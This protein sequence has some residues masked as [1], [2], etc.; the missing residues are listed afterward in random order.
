MPKR[1]AL[2]LLLTISTGCIY[3]QTLPVGS[4]VIEDA[5]RRL[6]ISGTLPSDI[7]YTVRPVSA[8]AFGG[9]DSLYNPLKWAG[10]EKGPARVSYAK[11]KGELVVLPATIRQQ[12]NS[13]HPYGWNDGSMIQAKG[14]QTQI[15]AGI[16]TKLG[17]LSIQ[18][19]PEFVYAQ[20]G[21]F[22]QFPG[23]QNDTLWRD[24]Y[25]ILN[26]I[27]NPEKF[28]NGSYTKFFPGQSS[29]RFNY[30]KLSLGVSTENLWWG[31]GIRNSLLMSNTA[32]GFPH[33]TFNTTAP[34]KTGIGSFE[35]QIVSGMTKGSNILPPDTGRTFDGVRLYDPKPEDSK[36]Y[37][38]GMVI[39]WQPKWTKGL[40]LGFSRMF[41]L[42]N[43]DVEKSFDGYLPIFGTFFK[44]ATNGEDEKLRDQM[45]SLFVRLVLPKEKAEF[46]A[47]FGRND[48]SQNFTD[49][50]LEPEHARAYIVGGRKI[51]TTPKNRDIEVMF[52]LTQLENSPTAW[53]RAQ[54]GW[55]THYQVRHGYTNRGQVIGA[56][57]GPGSNSQTIGISWLKGI[58]KTGFTVE[59]VVRNNDYYYRAFQRLQN[60]RYHWVDVS[61]NAYKDWYYKRVLFSANLSFVR[62]FNYQWRYQHDAAG[63]EVYK[64]VN[65]LHAGL[66]VSYLF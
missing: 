10:D 36:R 49:A 65:Q 22:E 54:E 28:G 19:R 31:P 44:G 24:Y 8:Y 2:S 6:Q 43:S 16:Y 7:S 17:P 35:W 46:Y 34:V 60:P 61:L 18:L 14:Y 9:A 29:V 45:L 48:H 55:Y 12:F 51:I 26:R 58:E 41:Y 59:R 39:T 56:G 3:S 63:D 5:L 38:N 23:W 27:D 1:L 21:E 11:G 25:S 37:I 42:Y 33:I 62:S 47:E 52:E 15:S 30:K 64:N 13:H 20:N 66:S 57:I 50:V 53:L 40:Y 4:P 32:P